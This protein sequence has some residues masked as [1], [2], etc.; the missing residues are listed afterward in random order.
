MCVFVCVHALF[1]LTL[2]KQGIKVKKLDNNYNSNKNKFLNSEIT[3]VLIHH[4]AQS[5]S[6]IGESTPGKLAATAFS[7][8]CTAGVVL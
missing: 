6:V 7:A 2:A 1:D 5:P 8:A 4:G 3:V